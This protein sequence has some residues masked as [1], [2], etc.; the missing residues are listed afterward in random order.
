LY[1]VGKSDPEAITKPF[2]HPVELQGKKGITSTIRGLFDEGALVNSICSKRFAPLQ[3]TLGTPT[4]SSKILRM[5]NGGRVSSDGRW[6]GDVSLGGKTVRACFEIFPSGGGWSLLFGKPLLRQFGAIHDY[7]TDTLMIPSNGE[8]TTLVN[9]CDDNL[10]ATVTCGEDNNIMKGDVESPSRQVLPPIPAET[11]HVD[12]QCSN[13]PLVNTIADVIANSKGKSGR[14]R[15]NRRNR[16]SLRQWWNSIWTVSDTDNNPVEPQG[17]LQPEIDIDGDNSL[18]TR[19]SDPHNPRRVEE[20]LRQ[21]SIG[22]D[23]SDEQRTKVRDLL[24]EFADCFALSIREVLLIPGAEHRI[25][26]PPDAVFPKRIPHQRQLTQ[27]QREYL[28]DAIDELLAADMIEPIRPEDIKCV[29]PIT[30]AQKAHT[31]L[32]LSLD[33]LC[34]RVNEEC[35]SNGIPPIH[36][37]EAPTIPTITPAKDS[38]MTYDPTQPQKWRICQNYGALNKVTQVFP[39]PQGDIRTK[40]R[41]LSGHRWVHGFDF[42][43]GFYA[44]SIPEGSRP[45]L[46]YYVEGRG[47][48]TPKRMPFGLTGA[49]A[50]FAQVTADRLGDLL[51]KLQIELLVDDGGMAGDDFEDMMARTR[52]FL[53]RVRETSLSLSAKKSEFFMTEM[54]FAGA[55]VGPDGVQVDATKLT[56]VVDWRQPPHLLNLSSFLGLT[57]YFRDLIKGY[58]KIAQPLTDLVRS[59]VVPKDAGKAAYRAALRKVKLENVWTQSHK[60]AFLN[61]KKRL[62]SDPVLKAPRFDGTPFIV[63]SDGCKEGFGAMLAQ[64]FT[65]TRP[66][67]K[68]THKLHPIAFASKRTSLAEARYKPFLLEF[69][70]LK[71]ALDKFDDIVWGFPVEIETDCQALRDVIMSDDLNATH[72]RWRDGILAHQIV[73]ARHIPGR[74]NLVGDGISR[75]DEDLPHEDGDGSSWSVPPDWEHAR[76]LHY[77]LFSVETAVDTVHSRLRDRFKNENI[78]LE[79]VDALLGT[80]GASSDADRKRAAHRAEGYFVED[81]K[82]WRLGGSTPT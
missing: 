73:D 41:R 4:P 74:I 3:H 61:L 80:T 54:I 40:Q 19:T 21:V 34:H 17:D 66:G 8:W 62:T 69:A 37:V 1:N 33:E 50:T 82:L 58:A 14:G 9:K 70:A 43:S 25:H 52:Q 57:G 68:T 51:A 49:P 22:T 35:I 30:L 38:T 13:E 45:Y 24:A 67:G 64:R 29:S 71:F 48:F 55:R 11:E 26:I 7:G 5:A 27:A 12:K 20:V 60:N 31:N 18:F 39:M 75:K 63:T 16:Q 65:E 32:G 53:Q 78:F 10:T 56:A 72:A 44:V 81:G 23:L 46:A 6:C 42:A 28:S 15:R 2:I 76:G 47:Y 77:D 59:A 36:D 79:V